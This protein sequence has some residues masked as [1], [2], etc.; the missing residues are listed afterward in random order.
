[1]VLFVGGKLVCRLSAT[2]YMEPADWDV[3][4]NAVLEYSTTGGAPSAK[5]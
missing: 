4:I 5:L 3:L 1:M 2:V